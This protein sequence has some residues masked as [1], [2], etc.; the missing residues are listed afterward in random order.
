MSG[1]ILFLKSNEMNSIGL[2]SDY[3]AFATED[4]L[5]LV[6]NKSVHLFF[7]ESMLLELAK[8]NELGVLD[9]CESLLKESDVEYWFIALQALV[10]LSSDQAVDILYD[11]Y[12]DSPPNLKRLVALHIAQTV[13]EASQHKFKKIVGQ[14]SCVGTL[15][16]TLWTPI[17]IELLTDSC[18]RQGINTRFQ[19]PTNH[20]NIRNPR[21]PEVSMIPITT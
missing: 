16:I 12:L 17:A 8:R 9:I 2:V 11:L 20:S 14:F 10:V 4:L 7:R 6:H 21:P 5:N 18:K 15:D 1:F 13:T 19:S 3:E